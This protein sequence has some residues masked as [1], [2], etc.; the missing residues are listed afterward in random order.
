[1]SYLR[2]AICVVGAATMFVS[3]YGAAA[4]SSTS[5]VFVA[6]ACLL[7]GATNGQPVTTPVPVPYVLPS[8]YEGR[9]TAVSSNRLVDFAAG[10]MPNA[11]G[12]SPFGVE[13]ESGQTLRIVTNDLNTLVLEGTPSPSPAVGGRFRVR[14]LLTLDEMFSQAVA[15][16]DSL[17]NADNVLLFDSAAQQ[18]QTAFLSTNAPVP[19]WRDGDG[20]DCSSAVVPS[21]CA[22]LVRRRTPGD[23]I[24]ISHGVLSRT[25]GRMTVFPGLNWIAAPAMGDPLTLVD[26]RLFTGN[27]TTGLA[28][29]TNSAVAD[30]LMVFDVEGNSTTCF[31]SSAPGASGWRDLLMV[32]ATNAITAGSAL[33]VERKAPRSS[34]PWRVPMP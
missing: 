30:T 7:R 17:N 10:W 19:T 6:A 3:P 14:P 29:G 2:K 22:T 33:L 18:T 11:F 26:L 8:V 5:E 20:N 21:L 25:S 23:N 13:L 15:P 24:F 1:M 9:L 12:A 16:G 28:A 4:A 27:A 32:P 34:F 31:Y